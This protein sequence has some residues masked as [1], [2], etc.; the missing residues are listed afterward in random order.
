VAPFQLDARRCI[1]YLT[2]ENR[3]PIP[4]ELRP[5]IGSRIFGCDD[6][7]EVCPWN[8]FARA[9][10]LLSETRWTA[11]R[12]LGV[13]E[14]LALDETAFRQR[15]GRTPL[16]RA[17]H[18][19]LRRNVCVALGNVADARALPALERVARESEPLVAEHARWAIGQIEA[20]L[21]LARARGRVHC[22]H[23]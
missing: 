8:R 13:E 11:E 14:L 15:F 10:R 12:G 4:V 22:G 21:A 5:A 19:G 16:A 7:L 9:G 17:K 3:G 6:C 23:K 20:V 2:I 1:S 18:R